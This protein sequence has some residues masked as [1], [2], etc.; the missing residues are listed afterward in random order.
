MHDLRESYRRTFSNGYFGYC[1]TITF[2]PNSDY[3]LLHPKE[4]HQRFRT[5][6]TKYAK[7]HGFTGIMFPELSVN[8]LFHYHGLIFQKGKYEEHEKSLRLFRNYINRNYGRHSCQFIK[9]YYTDYSTSVF[10]RKGLLRSTSFTKIWDYISKDQSKY[11]F[12]KHIPF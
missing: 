3:A 1:L 2:K 10:T 8:G 4:A 12:L 6:F 11:Q 9:E 5:H 7:K